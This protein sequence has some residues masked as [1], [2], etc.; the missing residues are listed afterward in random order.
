MV[1][2]SLSVIVPGGRGFCVPFKDDSVFANSAISIRGGVL[3]RPQILMGLL[4][5]KT[6]WA[7]ITPPLY[8]DGFSRDWTLGCQSS[9]CGFCVCVVVFLDNGC[10]DPHLL[11]GFLGF[12]K[13][14][15]Y[16]A[17]RNYFSA[18]VLE[19]PLTYKISKS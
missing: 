11:S 2:L 7:W 16:V 4:S 14:V 17:L 15:F 8:N 6:G 1:E 5:E 12:G 10:S 13:G 9:V 19:L 18:V 3:L